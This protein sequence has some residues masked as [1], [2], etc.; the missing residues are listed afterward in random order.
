MLNHHFVTMSNEF[1]WKG[2]YAR[3]KVPAGGAKAEVKTGGEQD[4]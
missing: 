1:N 4:A 3:V 2:K